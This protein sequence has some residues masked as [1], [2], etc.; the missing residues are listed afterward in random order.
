MIPEQPCEVN[1][2]EPAAGKCALVRNR[3]RRMIAV[4]R[5]HECRNLI[6]IV[7]LAGSC[8]GQDQAIDVVIVRRA[9]NSREVDVQGSSA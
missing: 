9:Q 6:V 8:R 3:I 7:L 2:P 1:R 4:M 5:W